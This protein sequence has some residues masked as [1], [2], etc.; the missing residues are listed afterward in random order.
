MDSPGAKDEND[1]SAQI[2][3]KEKRKLQAQKVSSGT[4]WAGL[5]M[6]GMIGWSVSIPTL[7][8]AAL[9]IWLD[10]K[11]SQSFSWT[12][13]LLLVGLIAGCAIAW[14]WVAKDDKEKHQHKEDENE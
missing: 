13:S 5:G 12:L 9:G 6:F 10:K 14:F 11:H 1:F 4:V 3:R 8:G 2:A 7:L